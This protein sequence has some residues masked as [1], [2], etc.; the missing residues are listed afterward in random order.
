MSASNYVGEIRW[1]IVSAADQ[2]GIPE[3][4]FSKSN[5]PYLIGQISDGR[6]FVFNR[7]AMLE[8]ISMWQ[9]AD[10]EMRGHDERLPI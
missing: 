3:F 8:M 1:C 5:A 7:T 2:T 10:S 6:I 4:V 9:E